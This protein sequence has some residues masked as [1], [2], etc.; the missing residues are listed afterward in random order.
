MS[1]LDEIDDVAPTPAKSK[2]RG[3]GKTDQYFEQLQWQLSN[4]VPIKLYCETCYWGSS[5]LKYMF[6]P[7]GH[8]AMAEISGFDFEPVKVLSVLEEV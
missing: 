7:Y 5:D 2:F 8:G 6:C 4:T 1:I 3:E